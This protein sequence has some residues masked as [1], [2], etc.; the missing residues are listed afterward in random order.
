[1]PE[2]RIS[3][4]WA[5]SLAF[6]GCAMSAPELLPCHAASVCIEVNIAA[7]REA[8][9]QAMVFEIGEWWRKDFL[10][11][12]ESQGM[13][14][15]PRAGGLLYESAK[16]EGSGFVWGSVI[17]FEPSEHLAYT[18]QMA[19]PWGG[20]AHS[21]VQIALTDQSDVT[22]LV[23]SDSLVGH[24]TEDLLKS[25]ESGWLQLFGEGGLKSYVEGK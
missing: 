14:L 8:V 19:P 11:C 15:Q 7:T 23:L 24:L 5:S 3:W 17:R 1:M 10:V 13:N 6:D 25:L 16:A 12:A 9:W 4:S 21:I 22:S 2:L 18:A 20:P